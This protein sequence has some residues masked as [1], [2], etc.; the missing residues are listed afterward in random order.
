M[1][2]TNNNRHYDKSIVSTRWKVF[3]CDIPDKL[4]FIQGAPEMFSGI[5]KDSCLY[6]Q[7]R[8]FKYLIEKNLLVKK[9]C[10]VIR[11][12]F[13]TSTFTKNKLGT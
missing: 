12:K 7:T 10:V 13:K 3:F 9:N 4:S 1:T 5:K 6:W 2:I 11:T 8:L